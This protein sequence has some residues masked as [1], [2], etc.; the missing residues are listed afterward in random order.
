MQ[1]LLIAVVSVVLLGLGM[2]MMTDVKAVAAG[3]GQLNAALH[4][5]K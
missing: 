5:T 2:S 4:Q 1:N 3:H